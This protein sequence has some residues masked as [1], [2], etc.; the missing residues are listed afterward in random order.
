MEKELQDELIAAF[1]ELLE[2]ASEYWGYEH[3]GDPWNEDSR[4]MGEMTLDYMRRNG[5]PEYFAALLQKLKFI[6]TA[7]L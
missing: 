3:D 1:K 5:R 2:G 7:D 6:S 4:V